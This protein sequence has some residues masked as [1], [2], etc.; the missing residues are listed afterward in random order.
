MDVTARPPITPLLSLVALLDSDGRIEE[1]LRD[2]EDDIM[3]EE[4]E[5][6]LFGVDDSALSVLDRMV[7]GLDPS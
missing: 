3:M 5:E 4:G 2:P 7:D 6:D 1:E